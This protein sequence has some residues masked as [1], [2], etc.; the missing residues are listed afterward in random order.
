MTPE[1]GAKL[2]FWYDQEWW[3]PLGLTSGPSTSDEPLRQCYYFGTEPSGPAGRRAGL[4]LAS[5]HRPLRLTSRRGRGDGRHL[6]LDAA[7]AG[8][9]HRHCPFAHPETGPIHAF[10]L[11]L[12]PRQLDAAG[13]ERAEG[14][15]R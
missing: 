12:V 2:F 1:R 13:G 3:T 14:T 11:E 4:L 7:R 9:L 15:V 6:E 8:R 5:Y 10:G